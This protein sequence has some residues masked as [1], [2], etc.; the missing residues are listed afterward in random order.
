MRNFFPLASSIKC[1]VKGEPELQESELIEKAKKGDIAAFEELL[2]LHEKKV[3]TIAYKYMGNYEDAGDITQEAFLKAFQSMH[4]FRGESSFGTW[5]SRIAANKALDE[6]RKR[7]NFQL[8][9]LEEEIA[10]E[11]GSVSKEIAAEGATP[12]EHYLQQEIGEYLQD[13]IN[14]MR[15]EYKVVI[16]MREVE[17]RTYDEIA[18]ILNCSLGTVKSRLSR[19]RNYLKEKIMRDRKEL[20]R[21]GR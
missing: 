9:S 18:T 12:E 4:T 5:V 3:Y 21:H 2:R 13:L 20:L 1:R 14:E 19:A 10:L 17:G 6:L 7:K 16:V 8:T 11:T 15:E